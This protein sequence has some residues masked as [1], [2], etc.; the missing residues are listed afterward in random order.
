MR[1]TQTVTGKDWVKGE[2]KG[3]SISNFEIREELLEGQFDN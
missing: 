1:Q 2:K 3:R